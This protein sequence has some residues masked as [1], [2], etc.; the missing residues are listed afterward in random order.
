MAVFWAAVSS[1]MLAV[2]WVIVRDVS[3]RIPS[4]E[5]TFFATFF[6]LLMFIPWLVRRGK[7]V[8]VT[9]RLGTHLVRGVLNAVGVLAWFTALSMLPLADAA[10]LILLMPLGVIV[11]A[12]LF[13]GENVGPRRWL[14]LAIGIFGA[15]VIVR[16]GIET[17]GIGV[18]LVMITVVCGAT[19]RLI[20]KSLTRTESSSTSVIYLMMFMAPVTFIVALFVWQTPAPSDLLKLLFAG[21]LLSGAHFTF[22]HSIRL[23]DVSALEP[24][25]FTRLVWAAIL[26]YVFFAE[27]PDIWTWIGGALIV[28]ATT[29]V[30]RREAAI[31]K[32]QLADAESRSIG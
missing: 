4:V 21:F 18:G 32:R 23:A 8:F 22:M 24:V 10:A 20:A 14:A 27:I 17:V 29:Y 13:L 2:L 1:G 26:G 31:R 16:P 25:N 9:R 7:Q 15:L 28:G 6:G 30:A 3:S 12:M 5:V 11:G 19:Q